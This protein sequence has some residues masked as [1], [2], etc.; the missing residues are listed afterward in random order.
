MIFIVGNLQMQGY[1]V[2]MDQ[3]NKMAVITTIPS[4]SGNSVDKISTEIIIVIAVCSSLVLVLLVFV[5]R[6]FFN[7]RKQPEDIASLEITKNPVLS[8]NDAKLF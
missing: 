1:Q 6:D 4:P 2:F 8:T 5:L 7:K 3:D